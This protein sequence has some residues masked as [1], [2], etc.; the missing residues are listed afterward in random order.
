MPTNSSVFLYPDFSS[1]NIFFSS[2]LKIE[3]T[4]IYEPC[5]RFG[6]GTVRLHAFKMS[7][8]CASK[9][10][11]NSIGIYIFYFILPFL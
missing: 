6:G 4:K 1:L 10:K 7:A 9:I 5:C 3:N 11:T 2:V 8:F